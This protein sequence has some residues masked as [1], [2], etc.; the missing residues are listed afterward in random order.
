MNSADSNNT[1]VDEGGVS[2]I[3]LLQ[4]FV[5]N[6]RLLVIAPIAVGLIALGISFLVTPTYTATATF[7]PPQ[8]QQGM[9]SSLLQS[10]G[11]I[12]GLAGAA[13]GLKNPTDQYIS[14]LR[15]QTVEDGLVRRFSLTER[16][17]V[18]FKSDA[19]K[20]LEL[21]TRITSGKDNIISVEVDDRNPSFAA[22][23]ANAYG[24]ELIKLLGA[25]A[26]T[27]A[28]QR[29]VFFGKQLSA[30]KDSLVAAEKA[31]AATGISVS[32][33]NANPSTALAG[34]ASLRAQVTVQEVKLASMRS[35][36]TD[37]APEF[38]QAQAELSALR[39]ELSKAESAQ[40]A[41]AGSDSD[42]IGKYRDFKYQETLFDL[43][44]RQYEIARVDES[45]EG[46]SLQVIDQA[47]VPE[48]KA[49]PK[50]AMIAV[51]STFGTAFFLLVFVFLRNAW[52]NWQNDAASAFA[53]QKLKF[54]L[55]RSLG[56][57]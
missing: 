8:Q 54:S 4:V 9:A 10:L 35:Y 15:S 38:R 19:R 49:K 13:S 57:T 40:P 22:D 12:G 3:D 43:F 23:V 45:R 14:F 29:R 32:A 16:Y 17:D 37:A 31:L 2:I 5:E 47:Q 24:E 34:P 39:R 53:V 48:R 50:R 42:Y 51:I 11:A 26:I 33:L 36:L 46:S 44:S 20:T 21:N 28:Q 1:Q 55:R 30:T 56:R 52:K 6:L 25:L 18:K 27:E 41:T 7:L